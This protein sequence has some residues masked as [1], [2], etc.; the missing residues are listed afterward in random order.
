MLKTNVLNPLSG[1]KPDSVVIFLH[2]LGA[3]GADLISLG[4]AWQGSLP[5]TIFLSPDAPFPCDM[6][7]F[8]YQWFSLQN[9]SMSAI[10]EGVKMAAPIL[11]A[12][13]DEVLKSQ[14]VT[15]SR[16]ILV[17]FSQGTMMSL[18]VAPRRAVQLAGVLGYSGML[19]CGEHLLSEKKTSPP[20]ML[21]HGTEDA[22]IPFSSM[23]YAEAGL[24]AAEIPVESRACPG[25]SH[26]IDETGVEE[27]LKFLTRILA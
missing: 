17:G 12:Y 15:P 7:T 8:G 5:N 20:V 10:S 24:K 1:G 14:G 9:Q 3:D 25:L 6:A 19:V 2:G 4:S 23:A 26:G 27:G 18:Y 21:M 13:I 11:D 22:V 16:L